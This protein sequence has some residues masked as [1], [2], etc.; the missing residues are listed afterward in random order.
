MKKAEAIELTSRLNTLFA[1][2]MNVPITITFDKHTSQETIEKIYVDKVGALKNE[3]KKENGKTPEV[4]SI[5][6]VSGV[7]LP[8]VI[9][10]TVISAIADGM[11]LEIGATCIQIRKL[12]M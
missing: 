11:Q 8:F 7:K 9:R 4:M 10:D 3:P 6:C 5:Q 2:L 12:N 1:H